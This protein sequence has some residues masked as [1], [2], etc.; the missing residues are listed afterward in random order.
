MQTLRYFQIFWQQI[1][2]T[3]F[4]PLHFYP[5]YTVIILTCLTVK[6]LAFHKGAVF[7]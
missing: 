7:H 3:K 5:K 4:D 6:E 1:A 2:V